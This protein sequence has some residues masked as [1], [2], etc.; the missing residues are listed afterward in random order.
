[1]KITQLFRKISL[2]TAA[3]LSVT[4]LLSSCGSTAEGI[5]S[6]GQKGT[7]GGIN[8][9]SQERKILGQSRAV[10]ALAGAGAGALIAKRTGANPLAGALIGGIIGTIG[11]DVV[12]KK[13]ADKAKAKRLSNDTMKQM[14]ASVRANNNRLAAYNR[15]VAQRIAAIRNAKSSERASM[16]KAEYSSVNSAIKQTDKRIAQM[17]KKKIQLAGS[18]EGQLT[19]EIRRAK[20]ERAT[21]AGHRTTLSKYG[22]VAAR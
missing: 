14:I 16:A 5:G 4:M 3:F 7:I 21:L 1:M 18:Q 2:P 15:K 8:Y 12:G 20:S 11:G 22:S 19:V 10:G 6:I 17:E 13:Q 9:D